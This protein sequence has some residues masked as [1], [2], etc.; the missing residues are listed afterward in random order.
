VNENEE[1]HPEINQRK[2]M[3]REMD[4]ANKY[5]LQDFIHTN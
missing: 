3:E 5:A 2:R 4:N 1:A